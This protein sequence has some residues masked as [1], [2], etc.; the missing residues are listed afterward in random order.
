MT[1]R[2]CRLL[3]FFSIMD[4]AEGVIMLHVD[5]P[6]GNYCYKIQSQP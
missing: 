4:M 6:G 1:W 2:V 3:Q 5:N